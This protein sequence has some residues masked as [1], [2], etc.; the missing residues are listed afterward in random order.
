M[1]HLVIKGDAEDAREAAYKRIIYLSEIVSVLDGHYVSAK[2]E[3]FCEY[4][5]VKWFCETIESQA[6]HPVGTL[7]HYTFRP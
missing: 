3:D 6:P 7:L 1:I 4:A 5:V 2:T